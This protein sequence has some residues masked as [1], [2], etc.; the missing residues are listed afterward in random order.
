[1]S[2]QGLTR[3]GASDLKI[4]FSIIFY[5]IISNSQHEI[6]KLYSIYTI[7]MLSLTK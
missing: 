4:K 1:M 5:P 6:F 2:S 3:G 7:F